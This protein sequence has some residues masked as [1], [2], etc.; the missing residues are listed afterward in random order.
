MGID[1]VREDDAFDPDADEATRMQML[2]D[3]GIP[4]S[5]PPKICPSNW[6]DSITKAVAHLSDI[7]ASYACANA[8]EILKGIDDETIHK[9]VDEMLGTFL[10]MAFDGQILIDCPDRQESVRAGDVLKGALQYMEYC[11]SELPPSD[12]VDGILGEFCDE[13]TLYALLAISL[14]VQAAQLNFLETLEL[15]PPRPPEYADII[16]T[17]CY[18]ASEAKNRRAM[19]EMRAKL[20]VE[21]EAVKAAERKRKSQELEAARHNSARKA[22]T[23]VLEWWNDG[24]YSK[25]S[26]KC[27]A[28]AQYPAALET[29]GLLNG[30]EPF[31]P[32]T[33]YNW[34]AEGRAAE[35][36]ARK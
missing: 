13:A 27:D 8:L 20:S 18:A 21:T 14:F 24:D 32:S 36:K 5:L 2:L 25:F 17:A 35:G 4:S 16:G 28:A 6:P 12:V 7:S 31:K 15:P 29:D 26:A 19:A 33:V 1:S 11:T 34:L 9:A 10:W 3:Y 22:K 30:N 23:R